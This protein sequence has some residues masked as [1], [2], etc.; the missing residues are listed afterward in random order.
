MQQLSVAGATTLLLTS[1]LTIMV[2]TAIAPSLHV[3]APQLHM[4]TM[5]SWL[6]T[7]PSLGVVVFSPFTGAFIDRRGAYSVMQ[8]GLAGYGLLGVA[9]IFPLPPPAILCIRFLLGG[10]TAAIMS[11]GTALLAIHFRGAAR[12]KIMAAQGMAIELGGAFFLVAGGI[13]GDIDW[14][15]PFSIY[16]LAWVLWLL[17]AGCVP[18]GAQPVVAENAGSQSVPPSVYPVVAGAAAAMLLFFTCILELPGLLHR[19]VQFSATQTGCYM[20]AISLLAVVAAGCLTVMVKRTSA[21]STL[22]TGFA[23]LAAGNL[24]LSGGERL[25]PLLL[26]AICLGSGFG[27]TIPLLNHMTVNLSTAE[28]RGASLGY[29]AMAVFGGQFLAVFVVMLPHLFLFTGIGGLI[30]SLMIIISTKTIKTS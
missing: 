19:R 27:F 30:I 24:L 1:C 25:A 29:Y 6:I 8:A 5:G 11:A 10:A 4:G 7:L 2:G 20:G 14:R 16:L 17:L 28:N 12:L 9:A 18:K 13:L 26:A 3:I 21:R 22:I 23:L 15:L